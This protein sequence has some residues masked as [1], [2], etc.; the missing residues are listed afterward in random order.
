MGLG[1]MYQAQRN[2]ARAAQVRLLGMADAKDSTVDGG[3]ES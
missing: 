2:A 3:A 1:D